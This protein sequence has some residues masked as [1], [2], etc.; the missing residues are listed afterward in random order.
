[1]AEKTLTKDEAAAMIQA[2]RRELAAEA[3]WLRQNMSPKRIASKVARDHTGALIACGLGIGIVASLLI[4]RT[5]RSKERHP[6]A[7]YRDEMEDRRNS[8]AP[9]K[10]EPKVGIGAHLAGL[11]FKAATPLLIKNALHLFHAWQGTH[12]RAGSPVGSDAAQI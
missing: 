4:L 10:S 12:P 2:G 11:V 8:K 7:A 6:V 1:M 3:Q 5:H 9:K